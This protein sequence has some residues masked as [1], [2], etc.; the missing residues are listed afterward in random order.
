MC[1]CGFVHRVQVLEEVRGIRDLGAGLLRHGR[2]ELS[3]Q[4]SEKQQVLLTPEP[5]LLTKEKDNKTCLGEVTP[6][7]SLKWSKSDLAS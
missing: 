4:S 1:S 2:Q 6:P 3:F 5:S 7:E